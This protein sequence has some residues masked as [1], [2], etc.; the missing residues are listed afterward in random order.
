MHA[1]LSTAFLALSFLGASVREAYVT[2]LDLAVVL[3]LV[4]YLYLYAALLRYS[5]PEAE[6]PRRYSKRTLRLAGLAGFFST[7]LGMLVAFVPSRQIES[8]LLF[9]AKMLLGCGVF[10]GLAVFF[11][12]R[13]RAGRSAGPSSTH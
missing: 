9:E 2:L 1:L 11:Y 10:L 7:A 8:V 12:R 5:A 3:Q 4:P 6:A 13:G